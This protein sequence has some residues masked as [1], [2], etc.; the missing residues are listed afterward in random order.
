MSGRKNTLRKYQTITNGSMA[1]SLTSTVTNIQFLDAIGVQFNFTGTPT[2]SFQVQVSA[3]YA[4]DDNGNVQV[5]G[6]WVNMTLSPA[7]V[8]SGSADSIYIDIRSTS[9]PWM[10]LVYTRSS[11]SGTL[12]A[13]ITAKAI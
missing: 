3:D 13:F 6:N 5:A 8:A 4:Q 7:P 11:G 9:A 1:G 2:G 12:N 10:R